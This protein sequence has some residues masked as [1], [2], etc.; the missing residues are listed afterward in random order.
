MRP[1]RSESGPIGRVRLQAG[2]RLP[3]SLLRTSSFTVLPSTFWPASFDMTAFITRPMSFADDAPVS[4]IASATARSTAAGI[5]GRRQVRFEHGDFRRF[6]VGEILTAAAGELFDGIPAL[7]DGSGDDLSRLVLVERAA[8][9][10]LAIHQRGLEHA[11]RAQARDRPACASRPLS[12]PGRRQSEPTTN[13]RIRPLGCR[14]WLRRNKSRLPGLRCRRRHHHAGDRH[15]TWRGHWSAGERRRRRI[16]GRSLRRKS[17][18]R[19]HQWRH[20]RLRNRATAGLRIR[21]LRLR[22][23]EHRVEAALLWA[24]HR[25]PETGCCSWNCICCG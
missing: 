20:L 21:D 6:L 19:K 15:T 25:R 24:D 2:G 1:H 9:L 7:L 14:L 22:E 17:L 11:Q 8:L 13:L 10:D 23:H 5:G 3:P 4:A 16:G 18:R 12:Q